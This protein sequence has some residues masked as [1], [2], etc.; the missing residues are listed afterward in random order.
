VRHQMIESGS[1]ERHLDGYRF[2]LSRRSEEV[3]LTGY[4]QLLRPKLVVG[5]F[6]SSFQDADEFVTHLSSASQGRPYGFAL[7][8][9]PAANL[10][11]PYYR[12]PGTPLFATDTSLEPRRLQRLLPDREG[13]VTL[14]KAFAISSFGASS[15]L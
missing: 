9:G 2:A 15:I 6:R 12:G 4:S 1:F 11:H 7:T 5:R 8:G 10:L 14:L 13:T 3:L